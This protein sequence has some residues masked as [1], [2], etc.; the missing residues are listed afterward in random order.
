MKY[1]TDNNGVLDKNEFKRWMRDTKKSCSD[2][3]S[4]ILFEKLDEDCSNGI[5]FHEFTQA[6]IDHQKL[7]NEENLNNVFD[8]ID[9]NGNG[10][11][12][13]EELSKSFP[14]AHKVHIKE[15]IQ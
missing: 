6:V 5:S 10:Q 8:M 2:L 7:M 15:M 1:D 11:I 13:K 14:G 4:Q 12:S 9:T 3:D